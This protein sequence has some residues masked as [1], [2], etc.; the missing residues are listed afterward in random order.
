MYLQEGKQAPISDYASLWQ[1]K[2]NMLRF[3]DKSKSGSKT[4]QKS[5]KVWQRKA[6]ENN[7]LQEELL[8]PSKQQNIHQ[9]D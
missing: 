5:S 9:Q 2:V 4:K 8:Q 1:A 7:I 6:L 3:K